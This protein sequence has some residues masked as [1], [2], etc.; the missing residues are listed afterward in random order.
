MGPWGS[1]GSPTPLPHMD[2]IEKKVAFKQNA[3]GL[4]IKHSQEIPDWY[5]DELAAQRDASAYGRMG[6]MVRVC[7]VPEALADEWRKEG[8]D[9]FK[10]PA[11]AIV[12]RLKAHNYSKFL[13][14][15]KRV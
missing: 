13:T 9:V 11:A 2:L 8:F 1:F 3:D 10:E 15:L 12:A 14:T 7:V 6:D 4:L 5:L